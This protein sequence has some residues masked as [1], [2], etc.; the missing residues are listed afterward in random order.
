MQTTKPFHDTN[1]TTT[2]P[3]PPIAIGVHSTQQ[4]AIDPT[5]QTTSDTTHPRQRYFH[6][7]RER[8][9]RP[10]GRSPQEA[11]GFCISHRSHGCSLH[12]VLLSRITTGRDT[13]GPW[14]TVP[15]RP[16]D[17]VS[18]TSNSLPREA[19]TWPRLQPRSYRLGHTVGPGD[20]PAELPELP[21]CI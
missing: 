19:S 11:C 8:Y 12:M 21:V 16:V 2:Q 9:R 20:V 10:L 4:A 7:A 13:A 17:S 5:Q 3:T 1:V 14:D 18:H 15:K 6:R